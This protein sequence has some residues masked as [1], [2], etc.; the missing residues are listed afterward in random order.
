MSGEH[1]GFLFI[2]QNHILKR[3]FKCGIEKP[4]SEFYK[5]SQMGDGHLNK[6]KECTKKDVKK[7]YEVKSKDEEWVEKERA[8]GRDKY[9]R[10]NYLKSPSNCKTSRELGINRN[11]SDKLKRRGYNL[12]GKEAHHWN[13]NNP[14]S[15]ILLSRKAH[16]R[17]HKHIIV[18]RDDKFCYTLDGICLD[19]EEKTL[20]YY[21]EILSKYD[22]LNEQL[23]IINF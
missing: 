17:I 21:A 15:V 6:C 22:D 4:L 23:E 2:M 20:K 9:N 3:C 7:N 18:R 13:Y 11:T 12:N 5:H 16:H 8:R 1:K 10:L 14:N 19:T